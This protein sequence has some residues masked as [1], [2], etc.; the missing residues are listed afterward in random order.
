MS[1]SSQKTRSRRRRRAAA[2]G[3][4]YERRQVF[5]PQQLRELQRLYWRTVQHCRRAGTRFGRPGSASELVQQ[6]M[7]EARRLPAPELKHALPAIRQEVRRLE[8]L[9]DRWSMPV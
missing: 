2:D 8:L 6:A 7:A 1:R 4:W 5:V 3:P 9:I